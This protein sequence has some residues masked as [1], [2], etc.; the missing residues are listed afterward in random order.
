MSLISLI[1]CAVDHISLHPPLCLWPLPLGAFAALA[2]AVFTVVMPR[3]KAPRFTIIACPKWGPGS[4][5]GIVVE[6]QYWGRGQTKEAAVSKTLKGALIGLLAGGALGWLAVTIVFP[7][8]E[9]E[10]KTT[11]GTYARSFG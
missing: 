1:G 2:G 5:D 4:R 6:V 9:E 3:M 8:P 7:L 11:R 10:D